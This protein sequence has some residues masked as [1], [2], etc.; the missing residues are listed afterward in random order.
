MSLATLVRRMS[1]AGAP[2]EAIALA[3]EAIE[4]AMAAGA[5][6]IEWRRKKD[7]ERKRVH[8][9]SAEA[10]RNSMEAPEH[11]EDAPRNS[12]EIPV[13]SAEIPWTVSQVSPPIDNIT[14]TPSSSLSD[15]CAAGARETPRKILLECLSSETAEGVLA[16]RQ[17]IRKPLTL[18]ATRRLVNAF[19]LTGEPEAAALMMIDKAWQ[20][21]KP[22]WYENEKSNGAHGRNGKPTV[23]D[24]ARRNV[25]RGGIDF[26]PIPPRYMPPG[27]GGSPGGSVAR[28]LPEG[29]SSGPGGLRRGGDIDPDVV[30]P[31]GGLPGH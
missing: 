27:N 5:A 26:G 8:K 9:A 23:Q 20:G 28:M 7:R 25:E 19:D 17:A 2:P 3:V 14:L 21:F 12:S 22:D 15:K 1:E 4:T 10:P 6:E 18:L 13:A 30:P 29:R 16:H 24:I 11:S 31:T